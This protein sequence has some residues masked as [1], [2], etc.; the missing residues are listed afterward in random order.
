MKYNQT[1][2]TKEDIILK[3]EKEISSIELNKIISAYEMADNVYGDSKLSDGS[4]IFFHATRVC[5]ILLCEFNIKDSDILSAAL[6]HNIYIFDEEISVEIIDLNFGPYVAF[7]LESLIDDFDFIEDEP[8]RFSNDKDFRIPKD[9][10]LLIWLSNQLDTI[11]SFEFIVS[12]ENLNILSEIDEK[13]SNVSNT[14]HN[15][16]IVK[17]VQL[18]KYERNKLLG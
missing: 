8:I 1:Y 5:N 11:R 4:L 13:L 16:T 9:D 6:L 7:L 12:T 17:M 10:Y 14:N 18:L 3:L 2:L 15:D